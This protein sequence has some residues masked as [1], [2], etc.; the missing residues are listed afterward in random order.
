[1]FLKFEQTS[2]LKNL[3]SLIKKISINKV[4]KLK[5]EQKLKKEMFI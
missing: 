4:G 2:F 5:N 3:Y 1:M